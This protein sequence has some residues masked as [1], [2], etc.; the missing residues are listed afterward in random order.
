MIKMNFTSLQ[1][2]EKPKPRVNSLMDLS[3]FD[4]NMNYYICSAGGCGSTIIFN[5]LSNFGNVYHIHDRFPP[6]KLCF[7]GKENTEEPVY[8]EWFNKTEIPEDKLRFYKVIFIYRSPI[9]VIFSRFIQ[10]QGPN[11]TH[12][13][14]IKC[15][16][17]GLIGLGDIIKTGR[18]LYGIEEFYDNYIFPKKKRNYEIIC[19]K[20]EDFF[21]NI[22]LF[23]KILGIPDIKS[24]YPIKSERQK[25]KIYIKELLLIYHKL[26]FKMKQMPFIKVISPEYT[27]LIETLNKDINQTNNDLKSFNDDVAV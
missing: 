6:E 26:L 13:Q 24:L 16:N 15:I 8:D 25:K 4:K 19:I 7:I 22:N 14:H 18:D 3:I 20:Y 27:N 12:L 1:N 5:Y 23:N 10:P 9:D 21:N 17:N 2:L 11:T